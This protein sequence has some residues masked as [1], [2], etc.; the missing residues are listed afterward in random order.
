MEVLAVS[1]TQCCFPNHPEAIVWNVHFQPEVLACP[2]HS[3]VLLSLLVLSVLSLLFFQTVSA[4]SQR[5]QPGALRYCCRVCGKRFGWQGNLVRHMRVHSGAK[6]LGCRLCDFRCRNHSSLRCHLRS[7]H[8]LAN[9]S[10]ISSQVAS[11][12]GGE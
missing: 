12:P 6:P 9:P 5:G 3:F 2:S 4:T 1:L 11:G 10:L 8:G 7:R